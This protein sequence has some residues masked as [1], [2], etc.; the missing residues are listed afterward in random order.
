ME[1]FFVI[2]ITLCV[3]VF[4]GTLT[5][6]LIAKTHETSSR[7][8]AKVLF[9]TFA[10]PITILL[11]IFFV[12][13]TTHDAF[14]LYL[15]AGLIFGN[16]LRLIFADK[17]YLVSLQQNRDMLQVE[18]FTPIG[19]RH[20]LNLLIR[21]IDGI[22]MEKSNSLYDYPATLKIT[23]RKD[24]IYIW[25]IDKQRKLNVQTYIHMVNYSMASAGIG[26]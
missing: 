25:I 10:A 3:Y 20:Y 5:D 1:T 11:L 14:N 15:G 13:L 18:Y 16:L 4:L 21:G 26:E 7:L 17:K 9:H 19:K 6:V 12:M 23:Y 8:R 24:L 2:L 22:E